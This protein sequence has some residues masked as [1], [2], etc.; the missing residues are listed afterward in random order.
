[1]TAQKRTTGS[2][3]PQLSEDHNGMED[4]SVLKEPFLQP[5]DSHHTHPEQEREREQLNLRFTL[6]QGNPRRR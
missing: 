2:D 3:N 1:M 5:P 6:L 4:H